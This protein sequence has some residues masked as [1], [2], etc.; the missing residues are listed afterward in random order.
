LWQE[1][2]ISPRLRAKLIRFLSWKQR[3]GQSID[4]GAPLFVN[5][6]KNAISTRAMRAMFRKWQVK[7]GIERPHTFHALRH[8]AVTSVYQQ[9]KDL[10]IAQR[11]A[12]HKSVAATQ[13][14]AHPSIED[15]IN[16]VHGLPC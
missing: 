15:L 7:A 5:K 13:R 12:R 16:A 3:R 10:K 14:Y 11:F 2:V 8:T 4:A 9:Q 6:K 1:V